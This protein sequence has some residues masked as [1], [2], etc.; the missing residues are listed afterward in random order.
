VSDPAAG[1]VKVRFKLE[2]DEDGWPPAD[3]EGLWAEPLSDTFRIANTPWFVRNLASDDVVIAHAGSDG[4]LWATGKARWSGHLTIRVLP[5]R[6]GQGLAA[7]QAVLDAFRPLGVEGEGVAQFGLVAL[8]IP[9]DADLAAVKELLHC[10]T[11]DGRWEYEEG[12]IS[13]AWA[14]P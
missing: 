11:A 9:P 8:D 4:V 2:R 6:D 14:E 10:G 1:F 5:L 7:R 13:D 12:C 3:S